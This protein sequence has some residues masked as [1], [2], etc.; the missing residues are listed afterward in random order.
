MIKVLIAE[1]Q[2]MILGALAAMLDLEEDISVVARA[3]NGKQALKLAAE[4]NPDVVVTDIEMPGMTGLE[5]VK[6]LG[7]DGAKL[8]IILV[9]GKGDK[10]IKARAQAAGVAAYLDKPIMENRLLPLIQAALDGGGPAS[11]AK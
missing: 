4:F 7:R 1:D 6:A 9:T 11:A 2:G 3:P 10:T 5:L 8:P